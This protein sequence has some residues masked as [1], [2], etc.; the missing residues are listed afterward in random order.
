MKAIQVK[1][2]PSMQKTSELTGN[3]D[4]ALRVDG[5]GYRCC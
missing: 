1:N 2:M 5:D 3:S 4:N